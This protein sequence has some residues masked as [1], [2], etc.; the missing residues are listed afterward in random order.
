M[1]AYIEPAVNR[2]IPIYISLLLIFGG[3]T[4][5]VLELGTR[6]NADRVAAGRAVEATASGAAAQARSPAADAGGATKTLRENLR[7]PLSVLLLQVIVILLTARVVGALFRKIGQPTVVGEM[8]AGIL[9]GPSLLGLLA[10]GAMN[11]LF[12]P[13]SLETLRLLSQVGIIIFM[14]IV[15]M[16]LNVQDLRRK[17][18]AAILVSHASIVVPFFL[19]A[20]FSLLLY[21]PYVPD[22]I[23]FSSFSVFMAVAMSIT[24]F[25]VLASII[26]ERGLSKS[27]LGTM[28][29]ACAAVDDVTAWCLLAVVVASVKA[30]GLGGAAMTVVLM[31]LFVGA[32]LFL[33][34]PR[35]E[36]LV[37]EDAG[38]GTWGRGLVATVLLFVFL[39]ALLTEVIGIHALFGAMLAGV[40]MPSHAGL[41]SFLTRQLETITTTFL[42][43]LFFAFTGLRTQIGL[44]DDWS[45]WLICAGVIAV[46]IAGKVGGSAL[47]ARWV[48]MSGRD[49]LSLGVLMNTRGLM[50]LIVLNIGYDLG[51]LSPEIFS[52]MVFMAIATTFMTGPLLSLL[53]ARKSREAAAAAGV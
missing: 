34:K 7:H 25:P 41:R 11:F 31:L 38:E 6:Q 17:A 1:A 9:L 15:G 21:R 49:S 12:L 48:G 22:G 44:L 39:S 37:R 5:A 18:H 8:V 23:S 30:E 53:D 35:A 14:F 4:F 3:G 10:P 26:K 47:A 16:E 20:T 40:V 43:P 42:M 36:R 46:A 2:L 32:M 28:A 24:A 33:L 19:G 13:S 45:S 27:Y 29:I 52:I 50:E 51:I